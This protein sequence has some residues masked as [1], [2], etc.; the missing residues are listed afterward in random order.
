MYKVKT[1]SG[2]KKRFKKTKSGKIKAARP[3]HRHLLTKKSQKRKRS[4]RKAFYINYCD[5]GHI[6]PLLP[7]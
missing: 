7:Y 6:A 1:H 4:L 3:F 5:V 2:A